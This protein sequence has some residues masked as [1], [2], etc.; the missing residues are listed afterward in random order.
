MIIHCCGATEYIKASLCNS[1]SKIQNMSLLL[2][3]VGSDNFHFFLSWAF[4]ILHLKNDLFSVCL[5]QVEAPALK[6]N[7][8]Q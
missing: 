6:Q 7:I 8:K 5:F 2:L 3:Y 4:K 1:M